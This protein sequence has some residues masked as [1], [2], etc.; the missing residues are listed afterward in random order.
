MLDII[1]PPAG[2]QANYLSSTQMDRLERENAIMRH[3]ESVIDVGLERALAL[4][5]RRDCVRHEREFLRFAAFAKAANVGALQ[6]SG[7]TVALYLLDRLAYGARPDELATAAAGIAYAHEM[8]G[9][10][11]DWAPI[12][13]VLDFAIEEGAD[14]AHPDNARGH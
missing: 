11:L 9:R 5:S 3:V 12:R 1:T 2:G 14:D 7:H 8:A 13:A 6:A 10:Y 4:P